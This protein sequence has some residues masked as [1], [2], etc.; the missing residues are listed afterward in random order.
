MSDLQAYSV[1][2]NLPVDLEN[3]ILDD[4]AKSYVAILEDRKIDY[5]LGFEHCKSGKPHFH[6]GYQS[7]KQKNTSNET[8]KFNKCY[9]EYFSKKEF[10]NAIKHVQHNDIKL[11]LGYVQKEDT[12]F[13]TNIKDKEYLQECK[14]IYEKSLKVT[15]AKKKKKETYT[16]N[17]I[18]YLFRDYYKTQL[19][20]QRVTTPENDYYFFKQFFKTIQDKVSLTTYSRINKDK[21]IEYAKM[22]IDIEEQFI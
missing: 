3:D 7:K 18:G 11:L 20:G 19:E 17:E 9:E 15:K 12:N 14:G 22:S 21:T 1:T 6:I 16:V 4:I 10:P 5:A 8:K 2:V 13:Q